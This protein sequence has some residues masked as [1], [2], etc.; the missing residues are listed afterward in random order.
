MSTMRPYSRFL[1]MAA[2]VATS[3]TA[4]AGVAQAADTPRLRR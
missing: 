3:V 2:L 1:L 4:P